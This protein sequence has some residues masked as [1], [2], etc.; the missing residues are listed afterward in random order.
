MEKVCKKCK[1]SKPYS[2]FNKHPNNKK[3][4]LFTNCK[5]CCVKRANELIRQ[6]RSIGNHVYIL[7]EEHYAGTTTWMQHR[8]SQ[9]KRKGKNIEGYRVLYS[10]K[11]RDEALELESLLHDMG[12][13]GR[14][15]NNS[16]K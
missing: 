5:K 9:H 15:K 12:Y 11:N 2:E 10:T 7:P 14:H 6:K 16:Y 8:L 1:V 13:K 3:D 4:G